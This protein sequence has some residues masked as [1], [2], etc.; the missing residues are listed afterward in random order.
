MYQL[1]FNQSNINYMISLF[2]YLQE[3][4]DCVAPLNTMGMGNPVPADIGVEGTEPLVGKKRKKKKVKESI[5]DD[6]DV[7][8]ADSD[9]EIRYTMVE[10]WVEENISNIK[11][12]YTIKQI[13]G[14]YKVSFKLNFI[15]AAIQE[16]IPEYIVLDLTNVK[17]FDIEL[18]S[19]CVGKEKDKFIM[20]N[21]SFIFG[22]NTNLYIF[23]DSHKISEIEFDGK[24]NCKMITVSDLI[25]STIPTQG[26][27]H[28][29][30]HK[31]YKCNWTVYGGLKNLKRIS[32]VGGIPTVID[33][34]GAG[35][36]K[37]IL[38]EFSGQQVEVVKI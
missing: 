28:I 23:M 22:S 8:S 4:G 21:D 13:D 38:P 20:S 16:E 25:A 30:L 14:K 7:L 3:C 29:I 2:N 31:N 9:D 11:G 17:S 10:K 1:L 24:F 5:F 26:V 27:T 33:G 12:K 35:H 15:D 34:K 19:Y 36:H 37:I 32:C 6:E 18:I